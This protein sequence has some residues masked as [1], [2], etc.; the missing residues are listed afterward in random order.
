VGRTGNS[1]TRE[2]FSFWTLGD[3]NANVKGHFGAAK[4]REIET[5][6]CH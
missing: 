2:C 4:R 6:T 1:P 5:F 3:F